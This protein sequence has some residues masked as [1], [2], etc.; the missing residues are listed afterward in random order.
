MFIDKSMLG[1]WPASSG[2]FASIDDAGWE[3]ELSP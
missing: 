1:G 2:T 3:K